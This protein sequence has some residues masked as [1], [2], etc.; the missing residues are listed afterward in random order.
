M[1]RRTYL[2]TAASA[3]VPSSTLLRG[4]SEARIGS[5]PSKPWLSSSRREFT[6]PELLDAPDEWIERSFAWVDDMLARFPPS[7]PEHPVRRAAL[8][9]LDDILHIESA[10]QK[11]IVQNYFISRMERAVSEIEAA[12][13]TS[14]ARIWKLYNHGFLVRTPTVSWTHDVVPGAPHNAGFRVSPSLLRRLVAQSDVTFISHLHDDHANQEVAR[15]FT[16]AGKPVVAPENLWRQESGLATKL[17]YSKRST[18]ETAKVPARKG[19]PP[20]EVAAYP[21]HQGES[22]L[23][24]VYLVRSPEGFTT[25]QTGDQA[26]LPDFEWLAH[27]GARHRVDVLMP[28]CWTPDI[29]RM[30]WGVNPRYIVTGHENEMGHTVPHRE[31]YTQTWGHL[32]GSPYPMILMAWG[33]SY[34]FPMTA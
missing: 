33:E 19:L 15:M 17:L 4:Q 27:I 25:V 14:G 29:Q 13:V 1:N 28:N 11:P 12:R 31:D 8:I 23:N 34:S 3:L 6:A 7:V 10:P 30:V 16:E 21:G 18:T 26:Y 22:V 5:V 2:K 24:N 20:L 9:R 32:H